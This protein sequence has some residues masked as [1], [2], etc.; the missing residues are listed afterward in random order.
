M[1]DDLD[2][3]VDRAQMLQRGLDLE[4]TDVGVGVQDLALKVG[5]VDAIEVDDPE[6]ADPCGSQVHR[7]RRAEPA[8]A[9]AQDA[10][11]EQLALP[12]PTDVRQDDVPGVA[13]HLL[14]GERLG[15]V[16]VSSSSVTSPSTIENER[17]TGADRSASDRRR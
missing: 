2:R 17:S 11:V 3:R 12:G 1:P 15:H 5:N 6:L 9:D 10:R 13:L 16:T 14:L 8:R 7:D 4:T